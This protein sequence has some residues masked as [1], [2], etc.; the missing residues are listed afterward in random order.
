MFYFNIFQGDFQYGDER[1]L[2]LEQKAP[3]FENDYTHFFFLKEKVTKR[4]KKPKRFYR[5]TSCYQTIASYRAAPR[6]DFH[7]QVRK[8]HAEQP[9][10]LAVKARLFITARAKNPHAHMRVSASE[11]QQFICSHNL[12]AEFRQ[13]VF[14]DTSSFYSIISGVRRKRLLRK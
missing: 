4:S 8:N 13:A 12:H 7:S 5:F 10:H 6:Y 11:P 9:P 14:A 1:S 2:A 3:L